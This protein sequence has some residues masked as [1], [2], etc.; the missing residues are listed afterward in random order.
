M[1][2][3][4]YLDTMR[5]STQYMFDQSN[6]NRVDGVAR[7]HAGG[8]FAMK[9][10]PVAS[11]IHDPRQPVLDMSFK[12]LILNHGDHVMVTSEDQM[13]D[14]VELEVLVRVSVRTS[15]NMYGH[16]ASVARLRK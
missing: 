4:D 1:S 5:Y 7:P 16:Y 8:R 9:T 6:R 13:N 14:I 15:R 2:R 12:D 3:D 11:F 10:L